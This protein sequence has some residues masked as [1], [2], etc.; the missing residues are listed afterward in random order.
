MGISAGLFAF[1]EWRPDQASLNTKSS[2]VIT[3]VVPRA[4]GF[5]PFPDFVAF[6]QPLA[7]G[8]DTYTKALLH[9][10]GAN[11]STTITDNN[12]GGSAHTWTASGNAQIS[13]AQYVFGGASLLLDGTADRVTTPDHADFTLGSGNF[14]IDLR[15]RPA[16]NGSLL[17]IAGQCDAAGTGNANSAWYIS[18]TAANKIEFGVV[19]GTTVTTVTSTTSVTTGSFYHIAAVRTGNV[20]KLFINGTQEG[21]NIAFTGSVNDSNVVLAVGRAGAITTTEW[22]GWVDEFRLSV[23]I[24]RW[25]AAFISPGKAYDIA[26][27][28]TCRGMFF[29]RNADG[30]ITIFAATSTRLFKLNNT[31]FSWID[32][33]NGG[34]AY[35]AVPSSANWQFVQFNKYII[36]VQVNTAPQ[37]F[38]L[39]SSTAFANW[40]ARR[41]RRPTSRSSI[42]S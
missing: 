4:D 35:S 23:G 18:R 11:T 13:T 1:G 15:A 41:H 26:A 34:L 7:D 29:G 12:S 22:N 39:T 27:N 6:T 33:S 31:D 8:N 42:G 37:V 24:A 25:T 20:L 38:D 3:N 40:A 30:S 36:C 32:V 19:Q 10:D 21:G 9:F 2:P 17:Y 28:G 5:G 16:A 14:T